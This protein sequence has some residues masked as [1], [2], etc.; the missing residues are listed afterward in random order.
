MPE[1]PGRADLT[2]DGLARAGLSRAGL[3]RAGLSRGGL[4]GIAVT[5]DGRLGVATPDGGRFVTGPDA[6]DSLAD[7]LADGLAAADR[8]FRPRWVI[9]S[10]ATA[11]AC[12]ARGARLTTCWD[13]AAVHRLVFGGWRADPLFVWARLHG[14][15][16]PKA[17][18]AADGMPDLFDLSDDSDDPVDADGQL[19]QSWAN[20]GWAENSERVARWAAL[21]LDV[22]RLQ[23]QELA[24]IA[25]RPVTA[26]IAASESAAE[27]LCAELSAEGLPMNRTLAEKLLEGIIGPRPRSDGE[28]LR[29][30]VARD[31]LVLKHAPAGTVADLRSPAQVLALLRRVD[32][33]VP[34]TRATRLRELKDKHPLVEALLE[35]RKAERI[36]TTYG[37]GWLDACLGADGR[38]R[39][40]WT[41]CD[42]AAGRMTASAGLHNMPAL[43]RA[44]VVAEP[45]HVF[46]RADL[47]QIE[48]RV[49]AAVSGDEALATATQAD[50]LY[51]PVAAALGV[52]RPTA[53]VAVLGAMYG[54]TTGHGAQA[55]RRLTAAYPVAMAYL[56]AGDRAGQAGRDLRTYGAR[57]VEMRIG[58]QDTP[59]RAAARGRYGRNALVQGAAAEFFKM[60]AV[61]V[62]ARATELDARIVL[63]LHDELLV[64]VPEQHG[65]AAARL[66]D[67]CLRE[68][69]RRWAPAST[70]RFIA[71]TKVLTA[72]SQAK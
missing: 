67:D 7:S 71:D 65:E 14:Q 57:L 15:P 4:A 33:D 44:A 2:S 41:G 43:L 27:L 54:Q 1:P 3:S 26:A 69:A 5:P 10:G 58:D 20:G 31:A 72:W 62:R 25:D 68:T 47:G 6:T 24:K 53:K 22:A 59:A 18:A 52:D 45:G 51:A 28:A 63:C 23:K 49:L 55:L 8:T 21:A 32:I 56:D 9:W 29:Q 19:R 12:L 34:D 46:V 60:W 16:T 17:P 48:P 38:L 66:L 42:G 11:A 36:A 70:V 35:W 13:I 30:R 50:D 39:G 37:Y 40:E 61:T 64:H